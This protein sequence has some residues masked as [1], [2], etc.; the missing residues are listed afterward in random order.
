M[1]YQGQPI[2][3]ND[4]KRYDSA[5]QQGDDQGTGGGSDDGLF[6]HPGG[7]GSVIAEALDEF[8]QQ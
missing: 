1:W 3:G 4:T 8:V 7:G 2:R 6:D 5:E